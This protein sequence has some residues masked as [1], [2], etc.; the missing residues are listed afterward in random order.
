MKR[1]LLYFMLVA[2]V[3]GLSVPAM[4]VFAD[5]PG[6]SLFIKTKPFSDP[7]ALQS[8]GHVVPCEDSTHLY[9]RVGPAEG[10][11]ILE[12]HLWVGE[13]VWDVPQTKK[14]NPIPGQ[15]PYKD[16]HNTPIVHGENF[17]YQIPLSNFPE[18]QAGRDLNLAIVLQAVVQPAGGCGP[19][20]TAWGDCTFLP[21]FPKRWAKY[22]EYEHTP[23]SS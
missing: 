15:F 4:P 13:D 12:T 14:G 5:T 17:V 22:F 16:E 23:C 7:T 19:V 3:L 9:I 18:Y 10:W 11:Q 2:L 21:W 20:E 1:K 6:Q 8:V